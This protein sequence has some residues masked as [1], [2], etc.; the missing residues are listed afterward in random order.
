MERLSHIYGGKNSPAFLM[1]ADTEQLQIK[2]F[3]NI[4]VT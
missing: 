1:Y 3:L 2:T 4:G